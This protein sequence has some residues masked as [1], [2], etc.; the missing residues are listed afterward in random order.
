MSNSPSGIDVDALIA[1]LR[2]KLPAPVACPGPA[3]P[4]VDEV[5]RRVRF[6][7]ALRRGAAGP[8]PTASPGADHRQLPRWQ[9]DIEGFTQKSEYVLDDFLRLDD[10]DFV[11][12]AY[13]GL[14]RR[15]ADEAGYLHY[16]SS[17]RESRLSKVEIL[18]QLRWS[19]EGEARGVHVDGLLL[20]YL[21]QKWQRRRFVG[22]VLS[23]LHSLVR[24]PALIR[25]LQAQVDASRRDA[26]GVGQHANLL[27][28]RVELDL[29]Q[30][31]GAGDA[32]ASRLDGMELALRDEVAALASS[33]GQLA[34]QARSLSA[35]LARA[36]G[37]IGAMAEQLESRL[38][39]V[40]SR[41]QAQASA[42][43]ACLETLV[44]SVR[45]LESV[46]AA[47]ALRAAALEAAV[48]R[49]DASVQARAAGAEEDGER[50]RYIDALYARFEDRFRGSRELVRSR[51][52]QYLPMVTALGPEA[53][54]VD[55]GC[56][57]GEWLEL[58]RENGVQ[59]LG[60][61][62]NQVFLAECRNRG[63]AVEDADAIDWLVAQPD[64]SVSGVTSLHLVEHLPFGR[65]VE[66]VAQCFRVI[67]PGGLLLLETPNPENLL[68]STYGFYMDP[69][70]RNPIPPE[71]LQWLVAEMGFESVAVERLTLARYVQAPPLLDTDA[72]GAGSINVLLEGLHAAPDYAIVARRP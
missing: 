52:R 4:S 30:L 44:G 15:P 58:M 49:I 10:S 66:M 51:V 11:E 72:P 32:A 42:N 50:K 17:L 59:N 53:R 21:L 71:M 40:S 54:V 60:V 23:W 48:A 16:L 47:E 13:R 3:A 38:G 2:A 45:H 33:R 43:E 31:Q 29:S 18:A 46:A 56:G 7:I 27:A 64:A 35:D 22:P 5:L 26:R 41:L 68:V 70:H 25:R 34:D 28:Q 1:Q 65:V 24:L 8:A 57:R 39:A 14:L 61:D 36:Q 69:T 20:P 63:L 12:S 19:A 6:E 9:S 37:A 62:N 67:H 55:L